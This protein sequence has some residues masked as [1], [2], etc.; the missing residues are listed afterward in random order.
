MN[1]RFAAILVLLLAVLGGSAVLVYR[2]QHAREPSNAG[3]LGRPLLKGLAAPDIAAIRIADAK[4]I[5]TLEHK[6]KNW[7]I[8]E[9]GGFPADF[10][11]V[12]AFVL[13]ALELK[14]GQS[15]PIGAQDRARMHL[16]EPDKGEGAGT[17]VE[18]RAAGG[19]PLA[20]LLIG[21]KY[22]KRAPA[23]PAAASADGR[24]VLLPADPG[25]VYVVSDPLVQ[26][27]ARS[28]AWIDK[29]GISAQKVKTLQVQLAG[30]Q[31]WKIERA[32]ENAPWVLV[33]ARAGEKVEVTK[34]NA[35]SYSLSLLELADAAPPGM[36]AQS[37]GFDKPTATIDA[38][39]FD[40]LSYEFTVGRLDG[41]N[42]TFR[43]TR[44]GE[45]G[46]KDAA[47]LAREQALEPYTLL[48]AKA[49]LDDTLK[50]R[51]EL[52]EKKN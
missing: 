3:T 16:L 50:K 43:F 47:R 13:E 9:R 6:G 32:S 35:A 51:S 45:P 26:A 40:G 23:D 27:G 2:Q 37:A 39:T 19:K 52:L 11:Q 30:E 36:S 7:V 25:T 20:S 22:F 15:E 4:S 48:V 34:A 38:T 12:R 42:Y 33:G 1:P 28:A 14:I 21:K 5:L 46:K 17:L 24:F 29:S 41:A 8:D 10:D 44:Q 18:F 31:P 49:K